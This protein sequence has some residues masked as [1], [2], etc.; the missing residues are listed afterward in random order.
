MI[1]MTNNVDIIGGSGFIGTRLVHRLRSKEQL[2]VQITDK[3]PSR[4][5][6][7]LVILGD[8]RSVDQ[9]GVAIAKPL[10]PE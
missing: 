1:F 3:A 2:A 7:D 6:P 9:L 4:A 5:H 10:Q 8:V